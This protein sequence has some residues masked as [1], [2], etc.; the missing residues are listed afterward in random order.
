MPHR[1]PRTTDER[2]VR[3]RRVPVD[4]EQDVSV[5]PLGQDALMQ[6]LT[7]TRE[8]QGERA[9]DFSFTV[10][11]ELVLVGFVCATDQADPDGGCGC[12]RAFSGLSSR[13]ATTTAVVRDLDLDEADVQSAVESY[14]MSTGL[15]PD[16]LGASDFADLV[17]ETVFETLAFAQP[18]TP[19]TVLRRRL[20][21]LSRR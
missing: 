18:W 9:G 19:G 16:T 8:G 6:L 3:G 20:D 13:K 14:F 10:E 5:G 4:P 2:E 7:A 11:G 17:E 12:G 15:G 1:V 21:W